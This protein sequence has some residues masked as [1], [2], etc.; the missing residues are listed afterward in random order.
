[1]SAV[2]VGPGR[3]S[4]EYDPAPAAEWQ[5]KLAAAYSKLEKAFAEHPYTDIHDHALNEC[6]KVLKELEL[7][8]F[9]LT[10]PT[11]T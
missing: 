1:M 10:Y 7:A 6:E 5:A 8:G 9:W 3:D 11:H 4:P 2:V